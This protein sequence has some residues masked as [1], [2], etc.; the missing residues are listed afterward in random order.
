MH[1]HFYKITTTKIYLC[2]IPGASIVYQSKTKPKY[3]CNIIIIAVTLNENRINI[4]KDVWIVYISLSI[5]A[6]YI[7]MNDRMTHKNLSAESIIQL[8]CY[9]IEEYIIPKYI[10]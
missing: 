6:K 4:N 5:N 2:D 9:C 7:E 10:A 3:E 1:T 8:F